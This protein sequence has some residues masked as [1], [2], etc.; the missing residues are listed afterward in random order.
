MSKSYTAI[1]VDGNNTAR[2]SLSSVIRQN[3]NMRDIYSSSCAREATAVLKQIDYIDWVFFNNTLVDRDAFEFVKEIQEF[4][5][6]ESAKYILTSSD[7]NREV[8][9]KAATSGVNAFIVKPF[10]P[11]IVLGK[12]QKLTDGK[13]Q[14][15]TRR[16]ELFGA[17]E[18]AV[19]FQEAK[20]RAELVDISLGG[21]MIKST[22]FSKGGG[23]VY[24]NAK[25][26]IPFEDSYISL[27]A[28]LIRLERDTSSEEPKVLAA[29]IFKEIKDKYARMLA[30]FLSKI[31]AR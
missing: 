5:S 25:I 2:K 15:Q 20:Y 22:N 9:L 6:T 17:F 30:S 31:Q 28:E 7:T 19:H 16:V 23:K 27:N 24:D 8:L 10:T 1:I 13:A 21:C 18:A 12:M 4:K 11:K 29:F 14:R 3:Y 26:R